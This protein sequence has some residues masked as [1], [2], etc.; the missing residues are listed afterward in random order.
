MDACSRMTGVGGVSARV[1]AVY[2]YLQSGLKKSVTQGA[3]P[4]P[5]LKVPSLRPPSL[6]VLFLRPPIL[7]TKVLT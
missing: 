2:M 1:N 3:P 4:G 7:F 5:L 6:L